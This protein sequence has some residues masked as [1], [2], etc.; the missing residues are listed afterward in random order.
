M[1]ILHINLAK[2]WRG[3]ERQTLFLMEALR[4]LGYQSVLLARR[5]HEL[6]GRTLK[7]GLP[8]IPITKPFLIAGAH[9]PGYDLIHAHEVR[10]LQ[11][12]A[13]WQAVHKQPVIT[14]RR[15]DN[16]P[17]N[18]PFTKYKYRQAVK[19]VCLSKAIHAGMRAWGVP[20]DKLPV[21][22]SA[23]KMQPAACNQTSRQ[24][25]EKYR[26]K[27][28]IGCVAA[29]EERKDPL[30]FLRVATEL[31][32]QRDDLMFIWVGNGPLL[33]TMQAKAEEL[34]LNNIC[35]A[36]FQSDPAPY[37]HLFDIY[38]ATS[39]S[40][41]LGSALLDAFL[42]KVPVVATA[43][44]GIPDIVDHGRTGLLAPVAD[45]KKITTHL[46]T[47]LAHADLR[48]GCVARAYEDLRQKFS[49]NVMARAYDNLYRDIVAV[50]QNQNKSASR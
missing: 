1:K 29:V 22:P 5:G 21:I 3:G 20:A 16:R 47:M 6:A 36:G 44:G 46:L 28:I 27:K 38:L 33:N 15:V 32:R 37:Y 4:P 14:T 24:L 11:L 9:L 34:N 31:S 43:A 12:A 41:G 25:R 18:N 2:G 42:Y 49:V 17:G 45:I 10:G 7:S 40:E 8:V 19:I 35:F 30:T 13:F 23:I 26:S 39:R 48:N 50:S